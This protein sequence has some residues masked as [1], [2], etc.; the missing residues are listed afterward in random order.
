MEKDARDAGMGG[1]CEPWKE[2]RRGEE[3]KTTNF[4]FTK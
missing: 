4:L 3:A 2:R 1:M